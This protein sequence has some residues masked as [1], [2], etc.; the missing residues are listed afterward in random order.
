MNAL[1][2]EKTRERRGRLLSTTTNSNGGPEP[3]GQDLKLNLNF[4]SY[5]DPEKTTET[6]KDTQ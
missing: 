3:Q 2:A 5:G 6:G 4:F 1:D